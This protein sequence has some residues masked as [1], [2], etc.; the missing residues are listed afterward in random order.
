MSEEK[1]MGQIETLTRRIEK[2]EAINEIQLLMGR[3]FCHH[4]INPREDIVTHANEWVY[5]AQRDDTTLEV[6]DNGLFVGFD[7]VRAFF[8]LMRRPADDPPPT[9][10]M[11]HHDL[12]SPQIVVA[13]DCQ[14]A[15]GVWTS[16]GHETAPAPGH[17]EPRAEWCW[18]RVA[19]D[20][21]KEN[22]MWKI[23]HYHWYR[24]F[25][26][27]FDTAWT[28][29]DPNKVTMQRDRSQFDALGGD[30]KRILPTTYFAGYSGD[31]YCEPVPDTPEP[32]E[33]WSDDR[34]PI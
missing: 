11:F 2:M 1:L 15:R 20:F 34:L 30:S 14:T 33:T 4:V 24:I 29:L 12:A 5:F 10:I 21:I 17:P 8:E 25:R 13:D 28:D 3:Y 16:P 27:P 31:K 7:N 26:C 18:G 23:W 22:G 9:G 6:A 32:Y 19:A